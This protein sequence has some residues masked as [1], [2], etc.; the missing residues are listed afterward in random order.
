MSKADYAGGLLLCGLYL[1]LGAATAALVVRRRLGWVEPWARAVA[2][3]VVF[4]A[5]LALAQLVPLILGILSRGTA[6]AAGALLLV[7]ATRLPRDT[8]DATERMRPEAADPSPARLLALVMI[9]VA[10]VYVVAFLLH[11]RAFA[12]SDYD[13]TSFILP[14]PAR[15][16]QTGS[17][18]RF[19]DLVPGWGY[20]AYPQ[21]GSLLQL[22]ALLPWHNDFALR[23]VNVPFLALA[24]LAT[25]ALAIE[26][27][28]R[29]SLAVTLAVL[30]VML[31]PAAAAALE[32]VQ[33]DIMMAAW[34]MSGALFLARHARTGAASELVLAGIAFGLSFGTKWYAGPEIAALC[35]VWVVARLADRV[36]WRAVL[37][38]AALVAGMILLLGGFWLLRNLVVGGDPLYPGKVAVL[39]HTIFDAPPSTSGTPVD[40][41]IAHYIGDP[42]ILRKFVWPAFRANFGWGGL[43]I[44]IGALGVLVPRLRGDRRVLV[45]GIATA[46]VFVVFTFMPYSAL[47]PENEPR[48][49]TTRYAAPALLLATVCAAVA[50][51]RLSARARVVV[52]V[53][54]IA[55]LVDAFG[56]YDRQVGSIR[57]DVPARDVLLGIALVA[58]VAV[59]AVVVARV[60]RR[61]AIAMVVLA[62]LVVGGL[63]RK[64]E[65]SF[66][67]ARYAGV[68]PAYD[69]LNARTGDGVR[70]AL[71]GEPD[72][73]YAAAPYVSF[74]RRLNNRVTFIGYRKQ[75]LLQRYKSA[76]PFNAAL[77]GGRYGLLLVGWDLAGPPR[78]LRWARA[79]GWRP[80]ASGGTFT[81]LEPPPRAQATAAG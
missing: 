38:Q 46:V 59:F 23:L 67:A 66:N 70:L 58:V 34:F 9:A 51:S 5:A 16:I 45:V 19:D 18:W 65:E 74:G 77:D 53:L 32:H 60:P 62:L 28:A 56:R 7:L 78:E 61:V 37:R 71:A 39:G 54:A 21:T 68:N 63:G 81:L 75:H 17:A 47:G 11:N 20:G 12:I 30:A 22:L 79:A 25:A 73:D 55:A 4:T 36:A 57:F 33:P 24:A 80:L 3:G 48:F 15:W 8:R 6:L 1:A 43:L 27:G 72:R 49:V 31:A 42:S 14:A 69:A 41:S 35:G 10:A 29:R 52:C 64:A 40:F 2:F 13:S 44:L 76:A 26:L 50:F